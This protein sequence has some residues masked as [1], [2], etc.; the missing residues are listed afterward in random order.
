MLLQFASKGGF[1][2]DQLNRWYEQLDASGIDRRLFTDYALQTIENAE[3]SGTSL[4]LNITGTEGT[5][6]VDPKELRKRLGFDSKA[7]A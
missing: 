5:A 3:N 2:G 1:Q 6:A 4:D 7:G